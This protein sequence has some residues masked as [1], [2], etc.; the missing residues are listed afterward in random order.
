MVWGEAPGKENQNGIVNS[1]TYFK[2]I[3]K[4]AKIIHRR[5]HG[6]RN[7]NPREELNLLQSGHMQ[8]K[9]VIKI[10]TKDKRSSMTSSS[11]TLIKI[12]KSKGTTKIAC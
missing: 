10:I 12:D 7:N 11:M 1:R 3:D 9:R 4:E 2:L 6:L 5:I 8:S